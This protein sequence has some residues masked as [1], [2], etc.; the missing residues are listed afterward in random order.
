MIRKTHAFT[1]SILVFCF[2]ISTSALNGSELIEQ[3]WAPNCEKL[4]NELITMQGLNIKFTTK[5]SIQNEQ[6]HWVLFWNDIEVLIPDTQY[7]SIFVLINKRN[8]YELRLHTIDDELIFLYSGEDAQMDDVFATLSGNK[9]VITTPDGITMTKD[10]FG[11]PVRLSTIMKLAYENTP[12]LLSCLEENRIKESTVA[13]ALILKEAATTNLLAVYKDIGDY[14]G[15]ITK[16]WSS[17]NNIEYD[18]NIISTSVDNLMLQI[19]YR[20]SEHS[21]YGYLPLWTGRKSPKIKEPP[22][23]LAALNTAL[24]SKS[25]DDWEAYIK[26]V[27]NTGISEKSILKTCENLNINPKP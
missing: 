23:W 14:N 25:H 13:S 19:H 7:K 6:L 16:S 24:K 18:L 21:K 5:P 10:M 9:E 27:K 26:E 12:E 20:I 17:G 22:D 8:D 15:W 3:P 1:I 11:G 4:K 2:F